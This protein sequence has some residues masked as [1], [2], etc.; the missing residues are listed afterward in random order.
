MPGHCAEVAVPQCVLVPTPELSLPADE[1]LG[2]RRRALRG[3]VRFL[4]EPEAHHLTIT[5]DLLPSL[6]EVLCPITQ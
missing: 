4:S 5:F 1:A 6:F 3:S 2:R